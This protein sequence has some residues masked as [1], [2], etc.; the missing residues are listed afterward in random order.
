MLAPQRTVAQKIAVKNFYASQK[1]FSIF[2]K[3]EFKTNQ[4]ET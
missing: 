4:T 1:L 2:Q 3:S